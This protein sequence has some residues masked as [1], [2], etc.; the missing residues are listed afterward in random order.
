MVDLFSNYRCYFVAATLGAHS[1][2]AVEG[3]RQKDVRFL[4]GLFLNWVDSTTKGIDSIVH[5]TQILRYLENFVRSGYASKMGK[6]RAPRYQLTRSGLLELVG[7][8]TKASSGAP[9]EQFFFVYYF[10]RTYGQRLTDLVAQKENGLPRSFQV[11]LEALLDHEE[12]LNQQIRSI[13][14]EIRKLESRRISTNS[15]VK[16]A[17]DLNRQGA[18]ADDIAREAEERYPYDLNSHKSMSELFREIPPA[19][20]TWELTVGNRNRSAYLWDPLMAYLE[21]YLRTLQGLRI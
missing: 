2:F 9:I 20:R 6:G 11:E 4:L 12:L 3:F 18:K 1:N 7:Q 16:L 8:L 17:D 14:L 5:N 15:V 10:V 19:L 21:S 13:Q